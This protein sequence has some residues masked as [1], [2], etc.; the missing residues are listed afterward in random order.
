MNKTALEKILQ[1]P[2]KDEIISKLVI[3]ITPKDIHEWLGMKY[4]NV[5]EAKF[6]IAEKSVKS[7]KDNYLDVYNTIKEDFLK[8]KNALATGT[9]DEQLILSVSENT[10]YKSLVFQ[11]VGKELNLKDTINGLI[12]VVETRLAQIHDSIQEN[13]RDVNSRVDRVFIEYVDKLGALLEKAYKITLGGPDQV[14]QHNITV[15]H[16]DQHTSIFYEAIKRVLSKMDLESSMYF[17]EI[18]N[19]EM[20]KLK[21]PNNRQIQPV[22]ERLAEV[23]VLNETIN[24]KVN[25]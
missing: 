25:E 21:D 10:D 18:F 6:V 22:E 24:Q 16:I 20:S 2:D 3:G 7:F 14:I 17:M 9:A 13:P 4:A 5:S 8:A 1:H 11:T 12:K 23:K 19:E 15:Q